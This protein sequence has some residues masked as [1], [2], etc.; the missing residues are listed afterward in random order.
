[1]VT[2]VK[3]FI[4][5]LL[6]FCIGF[7]ANSYA[8][9]EMKIVA[10]N[11]SDYIEASPGET[12]VALYVKFQRNG[13]TAAEDAYW[14]KVK[15]TNNGATPEF[16]DSTTEINR[17]EVYLDSNDNGI[18]DEAT[19]SRI[20][21]E[22]GPSVA[23]TQLDINIAPRQDFINDTPKGYF[24]VYTY[25]SEITGGETMGLLISQ[26]FYDP[27]T[28]TTQNPPVLPGTDPTET[29]SNTITIVSPISAVSFEE[30][31]SVKTII[32]RGFKGVVNHF[33]VENSSSAEVTLR[34]ITIQ[35]FGAAISFGPNETDVK[36]VH[37]YQDT[38]NDR[39]LDDS[40]KTP[41]SSE[42]FASTPAGGNHTFNILSAIAA[43]S[44]QGYFVEYEFGHQ[45]ALGNSTNFDV[46][47][48]KWGPHLL[49][50][51]TVVLTPSAIT[52]SGITVSVDLTDNPSF[53]MP[54]DT[55]QQVG[56][57]NISATAENFQLSSLTLTNPNENFDVGVVSGSSTVASNQGITKLRL[58][59]DDG[60]NTFETNGQDT[61]IASIVNADLEGTPT[62]NSSTSVTISS[63]LSPQEITAASSE[64]YFIVYDVGDSTDITETVGEA[65]SVQVP[66]AGVQGQG[67]TSQITSNYQVSVQPAT[68]PSIPISGLTYAIESIVPSGNI[69]GRGMMIPM[70]KITLTAHHDTITVRS[71]KLGTSSD[72]V[73]F[74]NR[75]GVSKIRILEDTG[76]NNN[77]VYDGIGTTLD[78]VMGA[79]AELDLSAPIPAQTELPSK[80]SIDID[81]FTLAPGVSKVMYVEYDVGMSINPTDEQDVSGNYEFFVDCQLED[82]EADDGGAPISIALSG[83]KPGVASPSA[84]ADIR[85][86]EILVSSISSITPTEVI[87]GQKTVPMI[88]MTLISD[89]DIASAS[90]TVLN[91]LL[92]FSKFNTGVTK[93]ILLHD[94]GTVGTFDLFSDTLV[95]DTSLFTQNGSVATLTGVPILEGNNNFIVAIDVGHDVPDAALT[96]PLIKPQISAISAGSAV[97]VG[98]NF[99]LPATPTQ[100]TVHNK[101]LTIGPIQI[102]DVSGNLM[103]TMN[104]SNDTPTFSIK[105]ALQNNLTDQT[106]TVFRTFP[107]FYVEN[108]SG[109]D[110]SH[111]YSVTQISPLTTEFT[112]AANTTQELEYLVSP[113][114]IKTRGSVIVDGFAEYRVQTNASGGTFSISDAAYPNT[115]HRAFNERYQISGSNQYLAA[116]GPNTVQLNTSITEPYT[117]V[118][119]AQSMTVSKGSYSEAFANNHVVPLNSTLEIQFA[120]Q[121]RFID[122]DTI[123]ITRSDQVSYM[124]TS[125][126][127]ATNNSQFT[128]DYD[129]DLGKLTIYDLGTTDG[130]LTINFSDIAGNPYVDSNGTTGLQVSYQISEALRVSDFLMNP[131]PYSPGLS[132]TLNI[133][134]NLTKASTVEIYIYNSSGR[135]IAKTDPV[136]YTTEGYKVFPWD[137]RTSFGGKYIG[138]GIF[139]AKIVATDSD[140][141]KVMTMT[142]LAVF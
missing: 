21:M 109:L 122:E 137:T 93:V 35:N 23:A 10:A 50:T 11:S 125:M 111:E 65:I 133:G 97:R 120:N 119:I 46:T 99:P 37:L 39:V 20:G 9:T 7:T 104:I 68:P 96:L 42:V 135:V 89:S 139:I 47:T 94:K 30:S 79:S 72:K 16:G 22:D 18:F 29:R 74:V 27:V 115:N 40:E 38:D 132:T 25:G 52:A 19:T 85:D 15:I 28:L 48:I 141:N 53:V 24:F 92:S 136:T 100:P 91:S 134:F 112:I 124:K 2:K 86:A 98:A 131:N 55:F 107:K 116:V 44:T 84:R 62:F 113:K 31:T 80:V 76:G 88:A 69:Y 105:I 3:Q 60:D 95:R 73:P 17:V 77:G 12:K 128:F 45:A 33:T 63:F 32:P 13:I 108:S 36:A 126:A 75:T 66:I 59:K 70:A 41:I 138:S 58:Y 1:M 102:E 114:N 51:Y 123:S 101:H 103:T 56:R 49:D 142:K 106:V 26:L 130:S 117:P 127:V 129:R 140:G 6:F 82:V 14:H 78:Q 8:L 121:G 61:L 4:L 64:D 5:I 43:S 57:V 83:T 54:G 34:G 90:I 118:T 87:I 110:S 81:D 67:L 71:I